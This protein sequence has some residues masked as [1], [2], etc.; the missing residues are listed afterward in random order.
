[1]ISCYFPFQ[2]DQPIA[3]VGYGQAAALTTLSHSRC[4]QRNI[5]IQINYNSIM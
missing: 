4:T 5:D 3:I 1:M 2:L